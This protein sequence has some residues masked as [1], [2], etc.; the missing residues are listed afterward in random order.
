MVTQ[1][2]DNLSQPFLQQVIAARLQV[3]ELDSGQWNLNRNVLRQLPGIFSKNFWCTTLAFF[4]F[5][6]PHTAILEANAA[7]KQAVIH[8]LMKN[9]Q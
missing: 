3:V 6:L 7:W 9:I 5:S 2:K 8:A 4:S 1:K